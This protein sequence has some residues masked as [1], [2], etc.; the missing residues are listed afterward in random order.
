MLN[1]E[2]FGENTIIYLSKEC[3][4]SSVVVCTMP[5]DANV[6]HFGPGDVSQLMTWS[7]I[8][9]SGTHRVTMAILRMEDI[10]VNTTKD[11]S[12][13]IFMLTGNNTLPSPFTFKI[14]DQSTGMYA[15]TK[16]LRP[17]SCVLACMSGITS[18]PH[19]NLY[20]SLT[21]VGSMLIKSPN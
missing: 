8:E 13:N 17:R 6:G 12:M 1:D 21:L 5:Y 7:P 11:V 15:C 10:P 4:Q 20:S 3:R 18:V 9:E 16:V 19:R 14:I 2:P